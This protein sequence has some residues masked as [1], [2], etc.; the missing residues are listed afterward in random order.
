[1]LLNWEQKELIGIAR[2]KF[3]V[4]GLS[5]WYSIEITLMLPNRVSAYIKWKI[6][7]YFKNNDKML[8]SKTKFLNS[9]IACF[10]NIYTEIN[11]R[12]AKLL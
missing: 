8:L 10:E 5:I 4:P 6:L 12:S 2:L 11:A 3:T 7:F 9:G 1:V